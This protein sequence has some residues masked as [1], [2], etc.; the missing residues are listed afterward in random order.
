MQACQQLRGGAVLSA[1]AGAG[2][3]LSWG[4]VTVHLALAKRRMSALA[5]HW[6]EENVSE[7]VKVKAFF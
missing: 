4:A 3:S 7:K 5:S 2:S 6:G 1:W